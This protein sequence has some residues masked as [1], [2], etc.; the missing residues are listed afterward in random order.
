MMKR[1]AYIFITS[2]IIGTILLNFSS[3][4]N[5]TA[6]PTGGDKDTIP[7]V[8]LKV[9]PAQR[10]INFPITD[11]KVTLT[12]DEYTVVKNA[13]DILLS[14]PQKKRVKTKVKGKSIVVTF[15]DTL[16]PD[17]TYTLD[18]GS[19][20]ADNNEGNPFGKFVYTFSTG[21]IID[22][23]YFTGTVM[24]A[25]TLLPKK[26]VLV[27]VY[28]D[29]SDSAVFKSLPYAATKSDDWGYFALTN[30]KPQKY[31]I[32][33]VEDLNNNNI[34]DPATE[35]VGF[36]GDYFQPTLVVND[37]VPELALYDMKDTIGCRSRRSDFNIL[38]FKE[39]GTTHKVKSVGRPSLRECY[40]KFQS[41]NA[42]VE[43][44]TFSGIPEK[45][46]IKQFNPTKDSLSIWINDKGYLPDTIFA[47]IKYMKSDSTN[48]LVLS[49]ED[50]KFAMEKKPFVA[51]QKKEAWDTSVVMTIISTPENIDQDGYK[52]EFGFPIVENNYDKL[53]YQSISPRGDTINEEYKIVPDLQDIKKFALKPKNKMQEGYTYHLTVRKGCFIDINGLPNDSTYI[54]TK[55]PSEDGLSTITLLCKGVY[56]RYIVDLVSENREKVF[57]S[58]TID[59]D[60]LLEFPYLKEGKYSIRITEDGNKNGII[61]IGSLL[62]HRQPEKVLLYESPGGETIIEV[63]SNIEINQTIDLLEMFR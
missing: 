23:M 58:Y 7:P 50:L 1:V 19:A 2:I 62:D 33:A 20:L 59:E 22:S 57:R 47:H 21:E 14:P 51:D 52:F 42:E 28:T 35:Q 9:E 10:K 18:F 61:D 44:I 17:R 13:N 34:Y 3:C 39:S 63:K 36:I 15:Q 26:G 4:A 12:F 55:L 46:L 45:D 37:T 8:L 40:V 6:A 31:R 56:K 41:S 27:S 60:I 5:T 54:S 49:D 32:Y 16:I 11:N 29:F 38:M 25:K 53:T 48:K 43:S 30:I 24:D